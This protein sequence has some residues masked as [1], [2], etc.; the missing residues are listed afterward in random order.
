MALISHDFD[1]F[2]RRVVRAIGPYLPDLVIA[3]GCANA[4]YRH[5]PEAEGTAIPAPGTMD[6]DLACTRTGPPLGERPRLIDLLRGAGLKVELTGQGHPPV[7]KFSLG[8]AG[9]GPETVAGQAREGLLLHLRDLHRLPRGP[10]W[11]C[12]RSSGPRA[13]LPSR[14]GRSLRAG[15]GCALPDSSGRRAG[16]GGPRGAGGIRRRPG[17]FARQR[18]HGARFRRPLDRRDQWH[19]GPAAPVNRIAE[20]PLAFDGRDGSPPVRDDPFLSRRERPGGTPSHHFPPLPRRGVA[21]ADPVPQ[22]LLQ[23]KTR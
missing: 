3:G 10:R 2:F 14:V 13:Q 8:T 16:L 11:S 12:R 1:L 23:R 21:G 15:P 20:A 18:S 9:P 6:L 19:P 5:H 22:P 4:L 17:C 7:M